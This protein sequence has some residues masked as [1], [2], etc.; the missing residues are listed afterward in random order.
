[1]LKPDILHSIAQGE[2]ENTEFKSSFNLQV[3]ETLVAF[4]NTKGGTVYIGVNDNKTFDNTFKI[5]AETIPNWLNEIKTKTQPTIIPDI[6][7]L[8]IDGY[9]IVKVS[10][11]EFP[12]KPV[13]CRGKYFKR[14]NN[15]NH[16]M[17]VNEISGQFLK[18]FNLSWDA[19]PYPN[20]TINDLDTE[21]I[22]RFT[23][24]V[25]NTG[26]FYLDN[27]SYNALEKLKLVTENKPTGAALL[28]FAKQPLMYNIHIGRFRT[29]SLII[30]DKQICD[31]L[32]EAAAGTM[33]FIINYI[34]VAFEFDGSLER[35]E[36]FE[37]PIP[38]LREAVINAIIHRDYTMPGDIQIKI[39]DDKI[40]IYNPGLLLNLTP[41]DL[42][43]DNYQSHLR[44]L[45]VAEA[46]YLTK[47]IEKYGSGIIRIRKILE[48]YPNIN[49]YIEEIGTAGVLITFELIKQNENLKNLNE[50][51]NDTLND[52][53]NDTINDTINSRFAF[54]LKLVKENKYITT[55]EMAEKCDVSVET[56]KRDISKMQHD[57]LIKRIGSRKTGYWQI[58]L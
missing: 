29:P 37:Y 47:N 36:I 23:T 54:I 20:H 42:L 17:T 26:R 43:K 7:T 15:S 8:E 19:Y 56:I 28:L 44:N 39:F 11:S 10:I 45:L 2:G 30:D 49:F 16:Q 5:E 40:T 25:N 46:F 34:K 1:M 31:T 21:K 27:D 12:I 14:V 33:K 35:K 50:P 9:K 38:A 53:L 3:I 55:E 6:E 24:N 58:K 4:A 32:F 48:D 13:A 51:V 52:T 41:R 18:T 22:V 57:N